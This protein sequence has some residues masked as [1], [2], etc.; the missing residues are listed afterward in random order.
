MAQ[1]DGLISQNPAMRLGKR[2]LRKDPEATFKPKGI[3]TEQEIRAL[4]KKAYYLDPRA[5]VIVMILARTGMRIGE[6]SALKIEDF[7]FRE[8]LIHVQRTRGSRKKT[9]RLQAV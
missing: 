1:E 8:R 2:F 5:H 7:H 3:F 9:P 4:L 6:A